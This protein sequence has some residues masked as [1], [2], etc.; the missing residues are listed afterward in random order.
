MNR[1][2]PTYYTTEHLPQ[3]WVAAICSEQ[4]IRALS[5][6][7]SS[8][9]LAMASIKLNCSTGTR[10]P[11][12]FTQLLHEL[13][14]YFDGKTQHFSSPVDLSHRPPFFQRAWDLCRTIPYGET[15]SYGWLASE[16]GSP[17]AHRAVGQAMARNPVPI[18]VPCH[19][20]LRANGTLGGFAW[21]LEFK[22]WLLDLESK[23]V[24][25]QHAQRKDI[26]AI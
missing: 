25:E 26:D 19:R 20:V 24:G 13:T 14:L 17:T 21:G 16:C 22:S 9:A 7:S 1:T 12:K 3:G 6:P 18:F 4:G 11:E 23:N 15:R 2:H 8:E 5:P 10:R